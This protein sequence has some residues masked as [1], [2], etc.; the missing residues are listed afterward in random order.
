MSFLL[1]RI[2]RH[3]LIAAITA[4]GLA[5]APRAGPV[6]PSD[7]D[8]E[9]GQDTGLAVAGDHVAARQQESRVPPDAEAIDRGRI[10]YGFYCMNCHGGDGRGGVD[11]G[12]D[13][14]ESRMLSADD[15]GREFAAFLPVGRPEQRMPPTPL[16]ENDIAD[17]WAF[18]RV[19]IGAAVPVDPAA[20][21]E[22]IAGDPQAGERHFRT[23]GCA[24]CHSVTGDLK[25][26]GARL[27]ASAI[28]E[29]LLQLP[30]PGD[31]A[32]TARAERAAA[33]ARRRH[34][35]SVKKLGE[36]AV[37]DLAVYLA[38]RR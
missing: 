21:D 35:D 8:V 30:P 19:M 2:V 31:K 13:L 38:A 5:V 36:Q 34:A 23:A 3:S 1:H 4:A 20:R 16:S 29:R 26:I 24:R 11:G 14:R 32:T 15:G 33:D 7:V 37:R 12:S 22:P 17:L 9:S 10:T 25:G 27:D 28:H 6:L 18:L